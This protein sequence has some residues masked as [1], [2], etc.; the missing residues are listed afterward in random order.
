MFSPWGCTPVARGSTTLLLSV[1]DHSVEGDGADLVDVQRPQL[2]A[3]LPPR[4]LDIL[5][6][7]VAVG[8]RIG[9]APPRPWMLRLGPTGGKGFRPARSAGGTAHVKQQLPVPAGTHATSRGARSTSSTSCSGPTDGGWM[10]FDA[11]GTAP[12][13]QEWVWW[14]ARS[15]GR[16][17]VFRAEAAAGC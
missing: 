12:D 15:Y 10:V 4:P 8:P 5:G 9:P 17:E 14:G 7:G 16:T 13:N 11:S 2:G 3:Q 6:V 1:T